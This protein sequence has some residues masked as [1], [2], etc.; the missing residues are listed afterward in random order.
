MQILQN[1]NKN[2]LNFT[3]AFILFFSLFYTET[4]IAF[5]KVKRCGDE[6]SILPPLVVCGRPGNGACSNECSFQDVGQSLENIMYLIIYIFVMLVPLY[7]IYIGVEMIRSQGVPEQLKEVRNIAG[8]VIIS[9]ILFFSAWV[10]IYAVASIMKV[11]ERVP[12]FLLNN[13]ASIKPNSSLINR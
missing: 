4:S 13:N 5:A 8:R 1:I 12:T 3:F 11:N 9:L 10:I 6:N 2:F 7:I